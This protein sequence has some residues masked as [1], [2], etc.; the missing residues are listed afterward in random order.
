[1][2]LPRTAADSPEKLGDEETILLCIRSSVR[3]DIQREQKKTEKSIRDCLK[4]ND[5]ASA[6][7]RAGSPTPVLCPDA[8]HDT[9]RKASDAT[10]FLLFTS[11]APCPHPRAVAQRSQPPPPEQG[12]RA[13][14]FLFLVVLHARQ[15]TPVLTP[16]PHS[17]AP[18]AQMNSVSLQLRE[19]LG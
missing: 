11:A 9:G 12:T 6:K 2:P 13:P 4:R 18:Q 14:R 7:A 17:S 16:D 19:N 1:M 15:F 10:P 3:A 5:K 8:S